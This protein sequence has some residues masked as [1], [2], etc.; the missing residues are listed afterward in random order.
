MD[1]TMLL[2]VRKTV[3]LFAV[4]L[5]MAFTGA[6]TVRPCLNCLNLTLPDGQIQAAPTQ[7]PDPDTTP[8][9]SGAGFFQVQITGSSGNLPDGSNYA[10]WC[11]SLQ[12]YSADSGLTG[13][14]VAS[15]YLPG[16]NNA[17]WNEVNY[18][19]NNKQGT[20]Q[21]VQQAIWIVLTGVAN[22]YN[23]STTAVNLVALAVSAE[24]IARFPGVN[25]PAEA[26]KGTVA[27]AAVKKRTE[28]RSRMSFIGVGVLCVN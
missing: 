27:R 20:V 11:A 18:I 5:A 26:A 7:T 12:S 10:G 28:R 25:E 22:V 16:L 8:A 6:A 4:A 3:I 14:T 2:S 19:L 24:R 15:T 23:P 9:A 1:S 13:Y 17:A 21:D